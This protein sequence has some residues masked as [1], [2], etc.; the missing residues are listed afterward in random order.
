MSGLSTSQIN[1]L[2][3]FESDYVGCF[4]SNKIPPIKR[5]PSKIVINT[6]KSGHPGNHWV[7]LHLTHDVSLYFDSF[8]LP[9]I[10]YDVYNYLKK[11]CR[12]ITYNRIC[13]QDLSS[14][15][16]GLFCIAFIKNV[17]SLKTYHHFMNNFY[18]DNLK[19]NDRKILNYI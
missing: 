14:S 7:A 1:N 15:A 17:S 2:L 8:G 4:P 13:I 19:E 11:Y 3:Q 16:C 5:F 10:E 6:E 18:L 9:V 12:N